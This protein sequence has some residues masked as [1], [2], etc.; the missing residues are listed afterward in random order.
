[1]AN[2]RR[3]T[4]K[5]QTRSEVSRTT[6]K[7]FRQKGTGR[8]RHGSRSANIF[9]GGAVSHGPQH[10]SYAKR[11]PQKM[12][13]L[14]LRS[15]LSVKAAEG[16]ILL[17][18]DLKMDQPRTRTMR[19]FIDRACDGNST[20][21]LL[22]ERNEAVERSIRNLSDAR[23]LRSAYLNV[24]DLLGFE[25][26]VLTMDALDSVVAHLGSAVEEADNA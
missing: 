19:E 13:Q 8:A 10:R 5:T 1:M 6:A 18:E 11:M 12:R 23:Y 7:W 21:V 3:G 26:L 2:A 24:R 15:A 9:V 25:R 14:A 22:S 4:H 17:V 16:A 20:L